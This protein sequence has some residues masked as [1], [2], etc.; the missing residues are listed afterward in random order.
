MSLR[1]LKSLYK[2]CHILNDISLQ[3]ERCTA[4]QYEDKTPTLHSVYWQRRARHYWYSPSRLVKRITQNFRAVLYVRKKWNKCKVWLLW[5]RIGLANRCLNNCIKSSQLFPFSKVSHRLYFRL[6][7]IANLN[8]KCKN[9]LA[10]PLIFS[11]LV[12]HIQRKHTVQR[13]RLKLSSTL[14]SF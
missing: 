9:P 4:L 2:A 3:Q 6:D 13:Q 12:S 8:Q 10:K 14:T 7:Y 1:M 11:S 5:L